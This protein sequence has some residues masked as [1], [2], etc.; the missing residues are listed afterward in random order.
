M[1]RLLVWLGFG[2]TKTAVF[3]RG[4]PASPGAW[5]MTAAAQAD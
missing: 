4:I 3:S 1:L 2:G 5:L